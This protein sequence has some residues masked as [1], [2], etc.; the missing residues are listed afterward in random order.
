MCP[1]SPNQRIAI[2][3]AVVQV[4]GRVWMKDASD[5]PQVR[6]G[7]ESEEHG[8]HR[9]VFL[10]YP[11]AAVRKVTHAFEERDQ[12]PVTIKQ[13]NAHTSRKRTICISNDQTSGHARASERGVNHQLRGDLNGPEAAEINVVQS[14]NL[15]IVGHCR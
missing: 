2:V 7:V 12:G 10:V 8:S 4:S 13:V 6:N 1:K 5:S 9:P 14:V 15:A 11:P 3:L